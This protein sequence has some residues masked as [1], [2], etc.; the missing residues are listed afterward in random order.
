MI[1]TALCSFST[2]FAQNPGRFN[3]LKVDERQ[4]VIDYFHNPHALEAV[5]EFVSRMGGPH[6]VAVIQMAGDR[7]DEDIAAFGQLA[8]QTF[9]ELVIRE[10]LP[11]F[12]RARPPGRCRRCSR[13]PPWSGGSHRTTFS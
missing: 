6:T 2:S 3:L 10:P 1:R 9:D 5:A 13:P 11:K 7:R 12:Q 4:V 8:G